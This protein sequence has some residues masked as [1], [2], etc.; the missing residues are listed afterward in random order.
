MLLTVFWGPR[1]DDRLILGFM[2]DST[3]ADGCLEH[4]KVWLG[5]ETGQHFQIERLEVLAH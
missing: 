3:S 2:A 4:K 1:G 5:G